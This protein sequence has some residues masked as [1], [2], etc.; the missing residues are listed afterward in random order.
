MKA[1]AHRQRA[2]GQLAFLAGKPSYFVTVNL[3][4]SLLHAVLLAW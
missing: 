3:P 2:P 4:A 1:G